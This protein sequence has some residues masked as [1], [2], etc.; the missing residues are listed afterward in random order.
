MLSDTALEQRNETASLPGGEFRDK[1]IEEQ[2]L[3]P[4]NWIH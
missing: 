4:V 3:T 2:K 1:E